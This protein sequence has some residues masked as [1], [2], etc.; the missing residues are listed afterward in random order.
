MIATVMT[1]VDGAPTLPAPVAAVAG[2]VAAVPAP[3]AAGVEGPVLAVFW[4]GPASL[5]SPIGRVCAKTI[6][7][8][9]VSLTK[10]YVSWKAFVLHEA[11][12]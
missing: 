8:C 10:W 1:F 9:Q 2:A 6:L 5:C 4:S 7:W 12:N 3:V 11:N